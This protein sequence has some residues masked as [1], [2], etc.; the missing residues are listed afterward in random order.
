MYH[1]DLGGH[2]MVR[3]GDWKL[4]NGETGSAPLTLTNL[5]QDISE[6]KNLANQYPQKVEELKT[7]RNAYVAEVEKT[8]GHPD[9]KRVEKKSPTRKK[10][11]PSGKPD[12]D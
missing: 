2:W 11:K 9:G 3:K 1:L 8:K 4:I 5:A 7:L 6:K 10:P 12:E